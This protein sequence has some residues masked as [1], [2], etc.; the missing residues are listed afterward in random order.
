M[1]ASVGL[2]AREVEPEPE[3]AAE[4]EELA[5]GEEAP[6]GAEG[7][8]EGEAAEAGSDSGESGSSEAKCA[9]RG[10]EATAPRRSSCSS[11]ASGIPGR[12]YAGNRHNVGWMVVESSRVGTERRGRASSPAS[13]PSY[14]WT[15]IDVALLKPETS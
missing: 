1:L 4:G 14:G 3:E 10:V 12:E 11:S 6:E 9:S 13:S 2:P 8:A 7:A 5:E 15:A